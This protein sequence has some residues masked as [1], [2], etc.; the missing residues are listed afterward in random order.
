MLEKSKTVV[1]D[2]SNV[3]YAETSKKR[4]PKLRNIA[5]MKKALQDCGYDK[6]ITLVRPTLKYYID[7]K[8][9][10]RI[11]IEQQK[12]REAPAGSNDDVYVYRIA[13]AFEADIV[14]N[15]LLRELPEEEK[16]WVY[17]RRISFMV[18]EGK[19]VFE[20]LRSQDEERLLI[21]KGDDKLP[22][23]QELVL[24]HHQRT[25]PTEAVQQIVEQELGLQGE[26]IT[27]KNINQALDIHPVYEKKKSRVEQYQTLLKEHNGET[28]TVSEFIE[29]V[30]ELRKQ[31][32]I[33]RC[34]GMEGKHQLETAKPDSYEVSA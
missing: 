18:I 29:G 27:F 1:V 5:A 2:G 4:R 3:A 6:V 28:I 22:Q 16:N 33:N 17:E 15:D 11:L 14:T 21:R 13:K 10:L 7:N 24:S 25:V 20:A 34:Q 26:G 12:I 32:R 30:R 9:A 8:E 31:H 23:T 19:I